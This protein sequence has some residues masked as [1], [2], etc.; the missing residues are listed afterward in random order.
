MA[1]VYI[2]TSIISYAVA[3]RTAAPH[4]QVRQED[5]RRWWD[6]YSSRF[7]LY[8]SQAVLDEAA[9]GDPVAAKDVGGSTINPTHGKCPASGQ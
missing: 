1:S 8:V 9:R 4:V 3:R 6:E 2:E 5:A 7:D